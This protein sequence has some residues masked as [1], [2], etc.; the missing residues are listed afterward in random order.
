MK[1]TNKFR[2]N[3]ENTLS[4]LF[5]QNRRR[6]PRH[7]ED[8]EDDDR[9]ESHSGAGAA[10]MGLGAAGLGLAGQG[11]SALG[12]VQGVHEQGKGIKGWFDRNKRRKEDYKK[13]GGDEKLMERKRDQAYR[14]S[15]TAKNSA[16]EAALKHRES[17]I[18]DSL[19]WARRKNKYKADMS[20]QKSWVG[21]GT[22]WA[23][24]NPWQAGA[25]VAGTAALAGGAYYL[26]KKRQ[27]KKKR[28]KER[29]E[30][31]AQ[32]R[33]QSSITSR[34][35]AVS[36]RGRGL[37]AATERASRVLG[38]SKSIRPTSTIGHYQ[39]KVKPKPHVM[40]MYTKPKTTTATT[41]STSNS[42]NH[43]KTSQTNNNISH[44]A[45]SAT[46]TSTTSNHNLANIKANRNKSRL[47]RLKQK[48]QNLIN[49]AK[50]GSYNAMSKE[51][52][53]EIKQRQTDKINDQAR[54]DKTQEIL[55]NRKLGHQE[56][57]I[58][59]LAKQTEALK[60]ADSG[61]WSHN[62]KQKQK[63]LRNA[64]I[65]HHNTKFEGNKLG[66]LWAR[67]GGIKKFDKN[68]NLRWGKKRMALAGLGAYAAYNMMKDDDDK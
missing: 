24:H 9:R 22:T 63:E 23:K 52:S 31:E 55:R 11:L 16:Q 66:D 57:N 38:K 20:K 43:W 61:V 26:W 17:E 7:D 14:L 48:K 36:M 18:S 49:D 50:S 46:S 59:E 12:T 15:K 64:R 6:N 60:T 13:F 35:F 56:K 44:P 28:E 51:R 54:R 19:E 27:E 2:Y 30:R 41:P 37:G 21:K 1:R 10:A 4:R 53:A 3:K 29:R 33:H 47:K 34:M 45:P 39:P 58:Q 42:G 5:A 68:G 8:D 40:D 65:E 67:A 25:A 62:Y 32:T